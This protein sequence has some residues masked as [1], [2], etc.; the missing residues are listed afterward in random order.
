M[1]DVKHFQRLNERI[2]RTRE[3]KKNVMARSSAY[4]GNLGSCLKV[5]KRS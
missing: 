4:H 5:V 3:Q 2:C 1:D